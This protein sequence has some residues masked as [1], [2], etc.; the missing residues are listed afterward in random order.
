MLKGASVLV[1]QESRLFLRDE[2]FIPV[3]VVEVHV[4]VARDVCLDHNV[5][6]FV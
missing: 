4:V 1:E 2:L 5:F 3:L 6:I